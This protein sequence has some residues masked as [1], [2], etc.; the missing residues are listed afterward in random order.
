M[1]KKSHSARGRRSPSLVSM[2]FALVLT[3]M[4]TV[5][6]FA[7]DMKTVSS[8]LAS[9]IA[10]SARKTVAVVDFTDL[11]GNATELGR[12]LAE[13][14]SEDLVNDA[15]GFRVIDREHLKTI[16]QE[17]KLAATGLI[18][19]TTIR[20]LGQIAG[21]DALVTGAITPFGDTVKL[22]A[23][24]LDTSTAETIAAATIEVPKTKAIEDLL[25]RGI[26]TPSQPS[27]AAGEGETQTTA[28]SF[29]QEPQSKKENKRPTFETDSYRVV[30]DSA[31]RSG[32]NITVLLT[33]ESISDKKIPLSWG[34]FFGYGHPS[35]RGPYLLDENG[36]RW[37]LLRND[38]AR[39]VFLS[40]YGP[41]DLPPGTKIRTRFVFGGSGA[42]G[43]FTLVCTEGAPQSG[44]EIVIHD[45]KPD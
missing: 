7:Q 22:S 16:L 30:I 3:A 42:A 17:H 25:K 9:R 31:R 40:G 18:D 28:S 44:R 15:N 39:V 1:N 41:V 38:D 20:K 45:L 12:F 34:W 6:L 33:F 4:A 43:S 27:R 24:V 19:P 36:G 21:V 23:K 26:G 8:S 37:D 29:P 32:N 11:Q 13:Q 14:L 2:R 5:P 10:A 35:D